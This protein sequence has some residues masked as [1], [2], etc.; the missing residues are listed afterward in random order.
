MDRR[1]LEYFLAVAEAGSFTRA[2][3]RLTIAQ[4]SLSH[5]VRALERELG[6]EL[7]ERRGR[8]VLLTVA[9]EALVAPARRTLRSFSLAAGAVRG[10]GEGGFG[11]LVVTT[12]TLWSMDPLARLVGA[13]RRVRPTVQVV[14]LDPVRRSDVLEAVGSGEADLGLLAGSPPAERLR[15]RRVGEQELVAV[16][17]R[18]VTGVAAPVTMT[19]LVPYGLISTPAGSALRGWVDDLLQDAGLAADVAVETPH[20]ASIVPLVA[21]GAGVA[22]LPQGLATLYAG[23]GVELLALDQAPRTPVHLL[24]AEPLT[25]PT[26]SHFLEVTGAVLDDP[27]LGSDAPPVPPGSYS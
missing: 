8:G 14:V 17:A 27:P 1:H 23:P 12:N 16:L 24:W 15:S 20:L 6:V 26:T 11:R 21:A 19:E 18:G 13:F 9:G 4:P 25:D 22:V 2:A 5:S 10:A 3:A 7:F